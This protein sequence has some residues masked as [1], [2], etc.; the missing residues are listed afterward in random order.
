MNP[1][2]ACIEP[3]KPGARARPTKSGTH[4]ATARRAEARA[5]HMASA[6]MAMERWPADRA[7]LSASARRG[8]TPSN[9]TSGSA[10]VQRAIVHNRM[11]ASTATITAA[12]D[13]AVQ[14]SGGRRDR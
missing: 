2:S 3:L 14:N 10:I 8:E 7:E 4:V 6:A 12:I 1:R 13:T 5:A 9:R 11:T